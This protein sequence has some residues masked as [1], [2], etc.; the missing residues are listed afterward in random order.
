[1]RRLWALTLLIGLVA[2]GVGA[3]AVFAGSTKTTATYW[4][5]SVSADSFTSNVS[6]SSMAGVDMTWLGYEKTATYTFHVAGLP[7]LAGS[8]AL[9]FNGYSISLQA[10]GGAGFDTTMKVVATGIGTATMAGT[11]NNPWQPHVAYNNDAPEGW[12]ASAS[13]LVPTGVWRGA[14]TLTVTVMPTSKTFMGLNVDSLHL[15]YTTMG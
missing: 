5:N 1:M 12:A 14:T 11:L 10:S 2:I 13:M 8:V 7:A 6:H 4:S 9:N 3:S 15:G